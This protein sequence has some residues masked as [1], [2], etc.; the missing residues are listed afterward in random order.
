MGVMYDYFRAADDDTAKSVGGVTGGPGVAGHP[1]VV[2]TKWVDPTVR[3]ARLYYRVLDR[4]WQLD[5]RLVTQ[6]L[7]ELPIGPDNFEEPTVER[8]ADGLRDALA[9]VV[10]DDRSALGQWWATT[11]EFALDRVDATYVEELCGE[12]LALCRHARDAGEHVYVWSCL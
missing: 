1:E 6:V 4:D 11:E 8:L 7:P 5:P 9:E 2:E 3:V 10:E 12:L